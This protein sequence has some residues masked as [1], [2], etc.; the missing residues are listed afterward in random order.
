MRDTHRSRRTVPGGEALFGR[1]VAGSTH[2]LTNVL[3]IIG[4]LAG[5]QDDILRDVAAGHAPDPGR[6]AELAERIHVQAG[7]GQELL[8]QLNRFAH[9]V[10]R[11]EE[12][13]D[14]SDMLESLVALTE[15][16]AR[17]TRTQLELRPSLEEVTVVGDPFA[18]LVAVSACVDAA[19]DA[20]DATRRVRLLAERA[21][22][23][24]R[25]TVECADPMPPASPEL[26]EAV[27]GALGRGAGRLVQAPSPTDRHRFVLE[28]SDAR[29]GGAG[30][31]ED[32][33]A[34]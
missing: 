31:T 19:V 22:G 29:S 27:E 1:L 21:S 23:P 4:E 25:I 11:S 34:P 8:R 18:M 9:S 2:E 30:T 13:Y 20:S 17:L 15:R 10:D 7:R 3:N 26:V 14:V 16:F 24:A 28:L 6:L 33:H 5:L 12:A 32:S